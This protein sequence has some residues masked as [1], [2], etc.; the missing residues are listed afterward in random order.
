MPPHAGGLRRVLLPAS[1]GRSME[2][3]VPEGSAERRYM[4][5][6]A[7]A[8]QFLSAFNKYCYCGVAG[9]H[10]ADFWLNMIMYYE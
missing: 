8:V 2:G 9:A 6:D 7:D 4:K 5:W 1:P 10:G 3:C